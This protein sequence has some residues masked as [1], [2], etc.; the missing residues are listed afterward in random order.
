MRRNRY[1]DQRGE[2][3]RYDPATDAWRRV[4]LSPMIELPGYSRVA[5]DSGYRKMVVF[6]GADDC[7]AL[8]VSSL[9]IAGGMIMRSE[10]GVEFTPIP[11][12]GA[13]ADNV[14]SFR[15]FAT[16][17]DRLH[18]SPAGQVSGELI[19]LNTTDVALVFSSTNPVAGQWRVDSELG[20]GDPCNRG[21][22]ELATFQDAL[23]AAT[24]N[25]HS[26]FQ[27]WRTSAGGPQ[28]RWRKVLGAG[29]L[30]GI[31]NEGVPTMCVF[32][33]GLYVGTGRQG[34]RNGGAELIRVDEDG[35][36]DLIVG[37]ARRSVQGWKIP[38][39]GI[40][41][42]FDDSANSEI[43]ELAEHDGWLYAGTGNTG[44]VVLLWL[45][46]HGG[47]QIRQRIGAT[48]AERAGFDL[49]RSRDGIGWEIVTTGG[50]GNPWSNSVASMLSTPVGLVVGTGTLPIATGWRG[51][52]GCEIWLGRRASKLSF[53]A[54]ILNFESSC[55]VCDG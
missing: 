44:S 45:Q 20:F 52:R 6:Q 23:Y 32:G 42:G 34:G 8:Y 15:S 36:W 53:P 43:L 25:S 5:R 55:G 28:Y 14:W 27:I 13:G 47:R 41:P 1:L 39:S 7:P 29:A 46:A 51:S 9:S 16:L 4:F 12:P 24:T 10:D 3:W 33:D 18:T 2:I 21:I 26:G 38:L 48:L 35:G 50:F 31:A 17:N 30:R 22:Y 19:E 11:R 40:G 37:A 49:W 54:G